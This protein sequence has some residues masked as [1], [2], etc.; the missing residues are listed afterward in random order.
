MR[1]LQPLRLALIYFNILH[2]ILPCFHG[3]QIGLYYL[4]KHILNTIK[5][6]GV[7]TFHNDYCKIIYRQCKWVGFYYQIISVLA[8]LLVLHSRKNET[9]LMFIRNY[10][11]S[12][13]FMSRTGFKIFNV[14]HEAQV[15]RTRVLYTQP[16]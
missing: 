16:N 4:L 10:V 11:F 3:C 13:K 2:F 12:L 14:F 1:T 7:I 15:T 6:L 5:K 8:N 9:P